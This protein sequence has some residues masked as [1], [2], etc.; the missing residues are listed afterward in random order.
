V[1]RVAKDS[2]AGEAGFR[3]GDV[4]LRLEG[5]PLLSIADVQWV[6]HHASPQ[7]A[8]LRADVQRG[9]EKKT[10]TLTLPPG[11]RQRDDISWRVSSWGMRRM[12]LGGLLLEGMSREERSKADVA[13]A[14]MAL[15]VK[16][17][18]QYGPH[19]AAQRAGFRKDDIVVSFD[20]RTDLAREADVLAYALKHRKPGE[21][22]PVEVLRDGK[23]VKLTLP[24]QE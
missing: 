24:M 18:G 2:P 8:T 12:A 11:W 3:P 13:D 20:G 19:A 23:R 6:L 5:Q 15:R 17:V 22:V 1:L 9:P 16:H 7:G 10:V 21:Q 14:A 4:I